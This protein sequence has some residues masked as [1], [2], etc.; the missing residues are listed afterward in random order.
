VFP[1]HPKIRT[2]FACTGRC[3]QANG[4]DPSALKAAA[5]H[6]NE[7]QLLRSYARDVALASALALCGLAK[8]ALD[9]GQVRVRVCVPQR[10]HMHS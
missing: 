5:K 2:Q 10:I 7:K 1:L 9:A 4:V 8:R 6:G 3:P